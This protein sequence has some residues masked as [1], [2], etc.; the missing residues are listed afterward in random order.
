MKRGYR[1][2]H[3]NH[4]SPDPFL[5]F[6]LPKNATFMCL[7]SRTSLMVDSLVAQLCI[8][9]LCSS[10]ATWPSSSPRHA[11]DITTN[12]IPLSWLKISDDDQ[13]FQSCCY[14]KSQL[15]FIKLFL[16]DS[17]HVITHVLLSFVK[18]V[19]LNRW[20]SIARSLVSVW[21]LAV[22]QNQ[23]NKCGSKWRLTGS[24]LSTAQRFQNTFRHVVQ[25]LFWNEFS[26]DWRTNL[27]SIRCA[28]LT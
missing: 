25:N 6:Y 1:L 10:T 28:A 8:S 23:T 26:D 12:K 20:A 15:D 9:R 19:K 22:H 2:S 4:L 16:L 18:E 3:S 7:L 21:P 17:V 14:R 5:Y 11:S 24:N 27:W 13:S